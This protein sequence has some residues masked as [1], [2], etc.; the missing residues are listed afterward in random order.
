MEKARRA[1]H[2]AGV[3]RLLRRHARR[4][5]RA[6]L[7]AGLQRHRYLLALDHPKANPNNVPP[8]GTQ[9]P[10]AQLNSGQPAEEHRGKTS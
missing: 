3:D 10:N 1:A 2:A 8:T 7:P 6:D 4:Q 9:R 5:R